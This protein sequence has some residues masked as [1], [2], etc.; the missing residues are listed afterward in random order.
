MKHAKG[1][2]RHVKRPAPYQGWADDR[3]PPMIPVIDPA[4]QMVMNQAGYFPPPAPR[5][6]TTMSAPL[7][8]TV[9]GISA[10]A[11]GFVVMI[12]I[13][14]LALAMDPGPAQATDQAPARIEQVTEIPDQRVRV[15]VTSQR[16]KV[17]S[18][19][20]C[21][22]EDSCEVNYI[23]DGTWVIERVVP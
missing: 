21:P 23:G 3:T 20:L 15:T 13:L 7:R 10:M 18:R 5:P 1:R 19:T 8:W 17:V 2:G 4:D 6:A 9:A 12:A 16:I 14:A 22:S 11:G